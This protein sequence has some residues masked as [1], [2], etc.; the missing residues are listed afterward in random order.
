MADFGHPKSLSYQTRYEMFTALAGFERSKVD[1]L[2]AFDLLT[3]PKAERF[4]LQRTRDLLKRGIDVGTAGFRGG[5]FTPIEKRLIKAG[6]LG[7]S[8]LKVYE[9][10]SELYKSKVVR[11]RYMKSQMVQPFLTFLGALFI[12]PIPGLILGQITGTDYIFRSLGPLLVLGLIVKGIQWGA[13]KLESEDGHFIQ[14]GIST[15]L[16]AMPLFGPMHIRVVWRDFI[17]HLALLLESGLPMFEAVPSAC[18]TIANPILRREMQKLLPLLESGLTFDLSLR[19]LTMTKPDTLMPLVSTG[20]F[21]GGLTT[22]L[23]QFVSIET[24]EIDIFYDAVTAW[25]PR[26]FYAIIAVFAAY[27]ILSNMAKPLPPGEMFK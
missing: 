21:S 26:I 11:W 17:Q 22:S 24:E 13:A 5:L 3:L 14:D 18:D 10:L 20:E 23:F 25:V 9:R 19:Q 15:L 7:G 4:R 16:M 27:T 8:P 12:P 1:V 6:T 2:K